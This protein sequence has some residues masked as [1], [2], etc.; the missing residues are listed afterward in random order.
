[1]SEPQ[2]F[3]PFAS[4]LSFGNAIQQISLISYS[5]GAISTNRHLPIW[6]GEIGPET[7]AVQTALAALRQHSSEHFE[8]RGCHLNLQT[9]GLDGAFHTDADQNVTH[10]LT[11]YVHPYEWPREYGGY[12]LVGTDPHKLR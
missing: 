5:F 7:V 4:E 2:V 10:S 11:W 3:Y 12:L 9:H 8:L 1:M 6:K